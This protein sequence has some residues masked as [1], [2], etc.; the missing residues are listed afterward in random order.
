M[1]AGSGRRY[2]TDLTDEQWALVEP[3]LRPNRGPGRPTS[4][5]LR[6]IVN[7]LL[8]FT[9]TGCQWRLLPREF[10]PWTTVRY[11]FDKWTRDGTL[12]QLNARLVE[13]AR[14]RGGRAAQ[15]TAGVLDSQSTKTTEAGG[16]RGYDGGKKDPG[17]EAAHPRG[18][19]RAP[20]GSAG[21]RGGRE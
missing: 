17:A 16:E 14:Q 4:V 18:H 20:A 1:A 13:Q 19:P 5:E 6:E 8:Y 21:P 11:Y 12:E 10:P 15:P 7:A 9:R 3:W 2:L